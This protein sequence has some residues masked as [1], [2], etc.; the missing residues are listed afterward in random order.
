SQ[1]FLAL[2]IEAALVYWVICLILSAIQS[3]LE[4]RLERYVA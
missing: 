2:Y 1:E 3:R 4:T